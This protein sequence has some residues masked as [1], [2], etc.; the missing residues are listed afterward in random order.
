MFK[1]TLREE[2]GDVQLQRGDNFVKHLE[3]LAKARHLEDEARRY[4]KMR[5]KEV[6]KGERKHNG[7][8]ERNDLITR[9]ELR[10]LCN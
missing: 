5:M 4:L 3:F 6:K 8:K 9:D 2:V 1:C 7:P 10:Q